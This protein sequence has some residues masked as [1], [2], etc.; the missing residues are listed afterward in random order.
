MAAYGKIA[1]AIDPRGLRHCVLFAISQPATGGKN[2]FDREHRNGYARR[3][4]AKGNVRVQR[5]G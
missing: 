1:S 2:Q 3:R 5:C 4:E